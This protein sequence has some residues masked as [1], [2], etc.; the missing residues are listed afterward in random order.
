MP[1][2]FPLQGY[3]IA[4]L[5]NRVYVQGQAPLATVDVDIGMEATAAVQI[6]AA[7]V[8]A[9]VVLDPLARCRLGVIGE[10]RLAVGWGLGLFGVR[11]Q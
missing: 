3:S 1:L 7:T 9:V 6:P 4:A 8:H 10:P 2:G 5:P 11:E